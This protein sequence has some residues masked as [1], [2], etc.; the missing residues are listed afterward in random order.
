[1]L[2]VKIRDWERGGGFVCVNLVNEIIRPLTQ[3]E[4][5]WGLE[6]GIT[7]VRKGGD[8][9]SFGEGVSKTN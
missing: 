2:N 5:R 1:M 9:S 7:G 6:N 3:S 8:V 4:V